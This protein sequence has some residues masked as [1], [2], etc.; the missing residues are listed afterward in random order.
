MNGSFSFSCSKPLDHGILLMGQFYLLFHQEL[1]F[2]IVFPVHITRFIIYVNGKPIGFTEQP[3]TLV[4]LIRG[5]R[6][7]C[8]LHQ[9]VSVH[10]KTAQRCVHVVSDGGRL[11]RPYIIVSAGSPLLTQ[12]MIEVCLTG[13]YFPFALLFLI[14]ILRKSLELA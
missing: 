13:I 11:C 10:I 8:C 1:P 7:A 6:R 5:L 12:A 14:F 4:R 2:F 3:G 9:F